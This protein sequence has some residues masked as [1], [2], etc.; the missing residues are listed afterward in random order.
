M[1]KIIFVTGNPHKV[2][3]A[4]DILSHV[5][6]TVEQNNCGYPELQEDELEPIARFGARWAADKLNREVMVDDSG[7]FIEAL[8]G[9]PGPYSAYVFD[10]LGNARILK[11]MEGETNRRAIFRC[12]IGYCRPGG[13]PY[14]FSGEV[15]GEIAD[16]MRGSG[17]FGY[18][19]IFEVG[20][21]TFGE[22]EEEEKN[23]LSHRYAALSEFARW[24]KEKY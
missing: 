23:R 19:P 15:T 4:S 11:L 7:L 5:G 1:R 12:V 21:A 16:E 3:E 20:G 18:D 6:I 14:L 24:L 13:E 22:M 9:F 2:R 10:T 8:R 17:G